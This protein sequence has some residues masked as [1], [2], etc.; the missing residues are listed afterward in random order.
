MFLLES[1]GFLYNIF[2]SGG[3]NKKDPLNAKDNRDNAV[4]A[5]FRDYVAFALNKASVKAGVLVVFIGYLAVSGWAVSHLEEGLERRKLAR[6]DS[7][8]VDF[9]NIEDGFFRE[10]PYRINVR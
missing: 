10:Y 8:S 2:C 7:Y 6:F 4:M 1:R 9:Y 5:F 3:I